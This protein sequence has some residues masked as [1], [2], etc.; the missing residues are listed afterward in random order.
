MS[1]LALESGL[2]ALELARRSTLAFLEDL[3]GDKLFHQTAPGTNHAV[4]IMG[5]LGVTD[6]FF[7][8]SVGG[9][10]PKCPQEWNKMFGMGSQPTTNPKDY[11]PPSKIRDNLNDRRR[12]LIAWF[13]SMDADKLAS[14]L[15]KEWHEFAPTHAA[16]ICSVAW[17]EGLHAGQLTLIR[18]SLGL[19][20][21]L[22]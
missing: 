10:E 14:P 12:E 4:W 11:P 18:R 20:P 3:S 1:N 22:G 9:Q 2:A 5:H 6:D 16:L 17:H 7:L 15:P 13:K 8:S 19:S 21:K